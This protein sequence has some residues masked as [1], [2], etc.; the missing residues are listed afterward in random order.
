MSYLSPISIYDSRTP[1]VWTAQVCVWLSSRSIVFHPPFLKF[2][3]GACSMRC[4]LFL[5]TLEFKNTTDWLTTNSVLHHW[6]YLHGTDRDGNAES[7]RSGGKKFLW[8]IVP[9]NFGGNQV[10]YTFSIKLI[11]VPYQMLNWDNCRIS[12]RTSPCFHWLEN[13]S[14]TLLTLL[15]LLH[16]VHKQTYFW[17]HNFLFIQRYIFQNLYTIMSCFWF[18]GH[19]LK[20]KKNKKTKACLWQHIC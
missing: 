18:N 7:N 11:L 1:A 19:N 2:C 8:Q 20:N 17:E 14:M 5:S 9:G 13:W 6:T 3:C 16:N 15:K 10:Y 4:L 12:F